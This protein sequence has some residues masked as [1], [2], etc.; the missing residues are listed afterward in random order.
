MNITGAE[1][2]LFVL[3]TISATIAAFRADIF[4]KVETLALAVAF[5]AAAFFLEVAHHFS[6]TK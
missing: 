2:V 5:A 1:V 6:I 4:P 3:A